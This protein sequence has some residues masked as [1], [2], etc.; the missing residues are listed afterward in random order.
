MARHTFDEDPLWKGNRLTAGCFMDGIYDIG[1]LDELLGNGADGAPCPEPPGSVLSH[2]RA[3]GRYYT[4]EPELHSCFNNKCAC[5]S[6]HSPEIDEDSIVGVDPGVFAIR[7]WKLIECGSELPACSGDVVPAEPIA[8]LCAQI[9]SD[10][11]RGCTFTSLPQVPHT[12][13]APAQQCI[14]WFATLEAE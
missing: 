2:T 7:H 3:L 1:A 13:C 4:T 6:D 12:A 8:T 10:S 9:E 5:D 11:E 14:D